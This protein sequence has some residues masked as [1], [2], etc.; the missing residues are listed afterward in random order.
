MIRGTQQQYGIH[1]RLSEIYFGAL[2]YVYLLSN[3]TPTHMLPDTHVYG[4]MFESLTV[5]NVF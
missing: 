5:F 2:I 4:Y 1:N 3:S